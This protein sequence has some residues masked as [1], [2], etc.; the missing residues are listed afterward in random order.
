MPQ[1]DGN[2]SRRKNE[3]Q[4][5]EDKARD[6]HA[7]GL[8]LNREQ[9]GRTERQSGAAT[10]AEL[11]S[12]WILPAALRTLSHRFLRGYSSAIARILTPC[13]F[14]AKKFRR[15]C[16]APIRDWCSTLLIALDC[17]M[18]SAKRQ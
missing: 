15:A 2:D 10:L 16:S 9:R 18:Q 12:A 6:G 17:Q 3:E 5:A 11:S 1:H 4:A 8:R 7:A 14:S 13:L